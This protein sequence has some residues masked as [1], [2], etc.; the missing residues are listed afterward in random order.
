M[1]TLSIIHD[2][3]RDDLARVGFT[4]VGSIGSSGPITYTK[5]TESDWSQSVARDADLFVTETGFTLAAR[6]VPVEMVPEDAITSVRDPADG[7]AITQLPGIPPSGPVWAFGTAVSIVAIP[8][9]EARL[10]DPNERFRKVGVL[11]EISNALGNYASALVQRLIDN[12]PDT[13]ES[14]FGNLQ[15]LLNRIDNGEAIGDG[16]DPDEF[17]GIA[18][19]ALQVEP[20][21]E[22][23]QAIYSFIDG[24]SLVESA[25]TGDGPYEQ[26]RQGL[27][28][29]QQEHGWDSA[30]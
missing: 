20:S 27:L 28:R 4:L 26:V 7:Y 24:R 19:H 2:S 25:S 23:F 22:A 11:A 15:R 5:K 8:D 18:Q 3:F 6:L 21:Y 9:W 10:A 29:I 13:R 14:A 1:S 16:I 30:N 12:A 17:L